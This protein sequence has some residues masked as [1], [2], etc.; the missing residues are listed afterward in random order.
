MVYI[1]V[2]ELEEKLARLIRNNK[3][4]DVGAHITAVGMV[5]DEHDKEYPP[6]TI[7]FDCKSQNKDE[8]H[9]LSIYP[10]QIGIL[11]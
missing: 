4:V 3:E 8:E 9:I 5:Y 1:S 2:K 7:L 11:Q 6:G 10:T